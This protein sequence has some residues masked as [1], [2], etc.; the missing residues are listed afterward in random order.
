MIEI[1]IGG[2]L[3]GRRP[4]GRERGKRKDERVH[5]G[6]ISGKTSPVLFPSLC[7]TTLRWKRV[8]TG[9]PMVTHK[10]HLSS[11]K[12]PFILENISDHLING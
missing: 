10:M 7:H 1:F 9:S 6:Y 5:A 4:K 8:R 11:Y 12:S 2:S 3:G